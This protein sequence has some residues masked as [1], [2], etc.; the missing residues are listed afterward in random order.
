MGI[1]IVRELE[2]RGDWNVTVLGLTTAS[3]TLSAAGIPHVGFRDLLDA[4][5]V[6]AREIGEQL[7]TTEHREG[8]G[9]S[10][11]E[12]VAYLGL[13]YAD[14]EVRVGR[15][16][17]DRQYREQGRR[18]FLPLGPL[19]RLI[20][21]TKPDVVIATSA[22][23]AEEAAIRVARKRG[24]PAVCVN[25]LFSLDRSCSYLWDSGYADVVTVVSAFA[26]DTLV[27]LGRPSEE[28][29][30]TGNPAFDALA[31]PA[32][33]ERGRRWREARNVGKRQ[34]VLWASQPEPPDP[35]LPA[36]VRMAILDAARDRNWFVVHRY[37]PS[38]PPPAS[39]PGDLGYCGRSD[40]LGTVLHA[41]DVVVV[42][43]TTLGLEAALADRPLVK[44]RLSVFDYTMPY[45]QMGIAV[46][47]DGLTEI[48]GAIGLAL[49]DRATRISL[50][51]ARAALPSVGMASKAVADVIEEF[52]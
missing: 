51:T 38:E 23:R 19:D 11:D 27:R 26:R 33:P 4:R 28:I 17:A 6:R 48:A 7:A 18:A 15:T 32:L 22:P 45:E 49:E 36:R 52:A 34:V 16:E 10:R 43:T 42:L 29:R 31:D 24:V 41:A 30:V 2:R 9:I 3:E 44:V 39:I 8:I 40:D 13:S 47:A 20:E 12:S 50:A 37:H 5:D 35:Q 14:L 1:P 21:Q 46:S 25:D